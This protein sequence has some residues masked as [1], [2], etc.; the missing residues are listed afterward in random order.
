[1]QPALASYTFVVSPSEKARQEKDRRERLKKSRE[2]TP[3]TPDEEALY[4]PELAHAGRLIEAAAQR[5]ERGDSY[6]RDAARDLRGLARAL[7][8]RARGIARGQ[9]FRATVGGRLGAAVLR[10][11]N[12]LVN[13]S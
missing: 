1:V 6:D 10:L 3:L 13:R 2:P 7:D 4:P 5:L 8:Q 11:A 12:R 9:A